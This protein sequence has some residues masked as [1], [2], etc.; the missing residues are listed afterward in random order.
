MK[1]LRGVPELNESHNNDCN[2]PHY[3]INVNIDGVCVFKNSEQSEI[4]P[5]LATVHSVAKSYGDDEIILTLSFYNWG[6]SRKV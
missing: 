5:I 1:V 3:S 4:I 6:F 2:I